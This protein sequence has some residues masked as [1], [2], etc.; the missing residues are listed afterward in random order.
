MHSG[1]LAEHE[2]LLGDVQS[3]LQLNSHA[4]KDVINCFLLRY[5]CQMLADIIDISAYVELHIWDVYCDLGVI[6][7][8]AFAAEHQD[9]LHGPCDR[10]RS[11]GNGRDC[12][13]PVD[14]LWCC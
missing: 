12:V 5:L 8:D 9:V 4:R 2:N 1:L 7:N 14:R 3:L 6:Y 13:L 11:T 10:S